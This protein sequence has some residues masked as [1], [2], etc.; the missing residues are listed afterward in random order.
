MNGSRYA[1]SAALAYRVALEDTDPFRDCYQWPAAPRLADADFAEWQRVFAG[2]VAG[3]RAGAR[4]LRR[5]AG[6]PG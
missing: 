3:N 2:G 6:A 1:C 4:R 5:R